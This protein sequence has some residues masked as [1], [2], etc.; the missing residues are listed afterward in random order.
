MTES[1]DSHPDRKRRKLHS[2]FGIFKKILKE[3]SVPTQFPNLP[4]YHNKEVP[5]P[6]ESTSSFHTRHER[7]VERQ[8]AENEDFLNEDIVGNLEEMAG[9][10]E[11]KKL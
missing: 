7:A 3:G 2:N 6:R 1:Q 8:E 5:K 10:L 4:S 11:A 9:K